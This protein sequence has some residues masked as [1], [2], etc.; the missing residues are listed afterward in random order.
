MSEQTTNPGP[1]AGVRVLD[2]TAVVLG[3]LATQILADYGADVIK[4]EG[5]EGDLMRGNGISLHKGMSSIFLT[6]NRNKRS[7]CLDLKTEAGKAALRK[8]VAG[9]DVLVHNMRV[10]AI[11]RLGFGYEAVAA[12]NPRIVYCEA[13][14]FGQNGPDRDRPA[15]DDIIQSACGM[16]DVVSRGRDTP[17][18]V[19]S[20]VAD[21]TT[22]MALANAVLAGL[23]HQ[24]RTGRGQRIEVPM[25]ET[26]TAF[27]L[28]EHLGGLTFRPEPAKAGYPRLLEG[29][30]K[31]HRTKDGWV[32][33]LPYTDRQSAAFFEGAG[34][35][36]LADWVR[37]T[38]R[39]DKNAYTRQLYAY[40]REITPLL[41][42]AEWLA[43]CDELDVP[44]TRIYAID[45]LPTHPHLKATDFFEEA[46]HPTEG[47]IRQMRPP[48]RFSETPATIRAQAPTLGQHTAEVLREAGLAEADIAAVVPR[49][50]SV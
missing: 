11:E 13:T 35:P 38:D 34:R 27:M 26:M 39:S 2:L 12:I 8:L 30:R 43:L 50:E 28:A 48:T 10:Q 49:A 41:T 5:P 17:D 40:M 31:P 19:P 7:V 44:A 18:Y 37:N 33:M 15:F 20:L 16:V 9:S 47:P 3:P 14:G 36:D 6:I 42:S 21:K 46:E 1:L 22:G 4:I 45:E 23:Y 29:G 25:L 24:A 32:A